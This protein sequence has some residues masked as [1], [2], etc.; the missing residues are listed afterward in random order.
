MISNCGHDENKKYSG[1]KAG[2]QNSEWVIRTWYN[3]P[4]N[5]VLRHPDERVRKEI[6][7]MAKDAANN[8][9]VGYDQGQRTTYWYQLRANKYDASKIKSNCEADCSAGVCSN[10]KAVG[11]RLDIAKLKNVSVSN[12]TSS[13]KN[14][15]K[16]AGFKVL[17][18]PKYLTSDSYLLEGD[19]LLSEG[20]HTCTNV[21]NGS[22]VSSKKV[23]Q[24]VK[25][26]W[27]ECL[28]KAIGAKVDNKAGFET[29]DKCPILKKGSR[30]KAVRLLKD[31][32]NCGN[33][34]DKFGLGTK[35]AVIVY[36]KKKGLTADGIV[37]QKTWKKLLAM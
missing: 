17:T 27:L 25:K 14:A 35:K 32:L 16:D 11:Y 8:N 15:L 6:A 9:H 7:K 22:K 29:L 2:D 5:V 26:T 13:L 10:V 4:W 34:T 23:T 24:P 21:T 20:H 19:I 1:G 3:R 18:D 33:S 37:G 31:R 36:Q 12:T 28:Q 30:G